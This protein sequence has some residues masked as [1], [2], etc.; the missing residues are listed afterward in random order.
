[1]NRQFSPGTMHPRHPRSRIAQGLIVCVLLTVLV[2]VI[3]GESTLPDNPA[4]GGFMLLTVLFATWLLPTPLS[5]SVAA[6]AT[7]SPFLSQ[8]INGVDLLTAR[9]QFIAIGVTAVLSEAAV[10]GVVA[11]EAQQLQL[12]ERLRQFAADA[13]HELRT[14]LTAMRAQLE[15]TLRQ[16]RSPDELVDAVRGALRNAERL[17]RVSESLLTMARIDA[18]VLAI[19]SERID[20]A[21]L[22]E[23]AQ[24]RW[25]RHAQLAGVTLDQAVE[26]DGSASGDAILLGRL[27]DNLLGNAIR[28]TPSG[29]KVTLGMQRPN[30]GVIELA[31]SDSGSGIPE[32]LAGT[33]FDRFTRAAPGPHGTEGGAGLGLALCAAIAKAHGGEIAIDQAF[34]TGTRITVQIPV[35]ADLACV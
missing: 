28:H 19:Q 25:Q 21:D 15:T 33:V 34:V 27:L 13:A 18:G 5:A 1:M 4:M 22:I 16:P 8:S 17:I 3:V 31:I 11:R 24:A 7:F 2:V 26:G 23:E 20:V 29:G 32:A 14:P 6:V 30:P 12:N 35:T 10:R 9:F